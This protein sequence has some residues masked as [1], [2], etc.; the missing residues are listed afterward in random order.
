MRDTSWGKL[1]GHPVPPWLQEG[2]FGIY[3]HWGIYSVHACGPNTTWYAHHL[4]KGKEGER[5][6]FESHF[7]PFGEKGYTDL[8]PLFTA[9][10]FDAEAWADLFAKSGA[11]FAGPVAIHHDGFAMWETA[12]TPFNS[13]MKG[14]RRDIVAELEKAYR[15][16]GMKYM[17]ALHHAENYWYMDR[18]PGTDGEKKENE[19]L[20]S[21]QGI[22]P[23]EK[24][25]KL[26]YDQTVELI[27]RF[28]PDALWFDF[29]LAS[30]PDAYKR[31]MLAY[32]RS[33][34]ARQHREVD[35]F[36]KFHDI[37]PGSGIIDL[38]LG[39]FNAMMYHPW[40]TDT[41]VDD[42]QAWGYMEGTAYKSA[43]ELVHYLVDNVS[44][45]GFLLLNVGPRADGSI[46]E[47]AQAAL[48]GIGK[49]LAVNGEAI[50]GTTPW[51]T[52]G[53][54]PT[55][56]KETGMFS[57]GEKLKY[58]AE[59]IR[60][61]VKDHAVYATL[62]ARPVSEIMID[63]VAKHFLPDEIEDICLLGYHRPLAYRVEDGKI[64]VEFPSDA[65]EQP[66]Y[67]LKISRKDMTRG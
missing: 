21:K 49:W 34:S 20:F 63:E 44:K 2:K 4:Y 58:T 62:L 9:E 19:M 29:G 27:E 26:W 53:A 38:E 18:M 40:I 50:Y 32:Y 51:Y 37:V 45:N 36:Y 5:T 67:C 54:G 8:I 15:A 57:E 25:C 35:V 43:A 12:L 14:P 33:H 64:R 16:K 17:L 52:Y 41:T 31:R 48:M 42:G 13:F 39:R 65:G 60:F 11:R 30:I 7:G 6:H 47:E 46:P 55:Q 3:T 56:M 66:A 10:K 22:W 28:T 59:D 61:T 23:F 24:F 1:L